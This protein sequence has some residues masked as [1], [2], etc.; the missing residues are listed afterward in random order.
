[1]KPKYLDTP[2]FKGESPSQQARRAR[3]ANRARGLAARRA[4]N[5]AIDEFQAEEAQARRDAMHEQALK[6]NRAW[7][8]MRAAER[9][10]AANGRWGTIG[11]ALRGPDAP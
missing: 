8:I 2:L 5:R 9:H 1:M 10:G 7:D 3:Q 6:D 4:T 11:A